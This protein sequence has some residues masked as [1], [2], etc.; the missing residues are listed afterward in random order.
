MQST[1]N[2]YYP[3][4]V[5]NSCRIF[6]HRPLFAS[7]SS[8]DACCKYPVPRVQPSSGQSTQ[9][10]Q[11]VVSSPAR[12][13]AL[14]GRQFSRSN[15]QRLLPL[16]RACFFLLHLIESFFRVIV[17]CMPFRARPPRY[18]AFSC[19]MYHPYVANRCLCWFGSRH[20][21][22]LVQGCQPTAPLTHASDHGPSLACHRNVRV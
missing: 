6:S 21:H 10:R 12:P 2:N 9:A 19:C 1:G 15:D 14:Q 7:A 8:V 17:S 3:W 18:L 22:Y 13:R 11:R 16:R 20:D 5:T 4:W